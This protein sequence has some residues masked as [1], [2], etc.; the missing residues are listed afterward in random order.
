MAAPAPILHVVYAGRGDAL[1]LE[2]TDNQNVQRFIL[3]D[4]G[5]YNFRAEI[6]APAPYHYY[7]QSAVQTLLPNAEFEGIVLT[8]AD[9]DHFGGLESVG[10]WRW[11]RQEGPNQWHAPLYAPN[12]WLDSIQHI[13]G[14]DHRFADGIAA[15]AQPQALIG[16]LVLLYPDLVNICK[17]TGP[18]LALDQPMRYNPPVALNVNNKNQSSIILATNTQNP[19]F[20]TGDNSAERILHSMDAMWPQA[21]GGPYPQQLVG[22]DRNPVIPRFSVYK[23]QHHGSRL[24]SIL[25]PTGQLLLPRWAEEV[26]IE[27]CV[28]VHLRFALHYRPGLVA[29]G[30][31]DAPIHIAAQRMLV[32]LRNQRG[33]DVATIAQFYDELVARQRIYRAAVVLF[34]AN[35]LVTE[36]PRNAPNLGLIF[37]PQ[38]VMV[39]F[40]RN[41][42]QEL[43]SSAVAGNLFD[44]RQTLVG[45]GQLGTRWD[46]LPKRDGWESFWNDG[47]SWDL[48][49]S[50]NIA[51]C[52]AFF[53]R[54]ESDSYVVSANGSHSHPNVETIIGLSMALK[55]QARAARL[56]VTSAGSIDV[57]LYNHVMEVAFMTQ[58]DVAAMRI[59]IP[60][61][62]ALAQNWV[63]IP[64]NANIID[65]LISTEPPPPP[66]LG[67][68]APGLLV[69]ALDSSEGFN[70]I[71][72]SGRDSQGIFNQAN[73]YDRHTNVNMVFN[74]NLDMAQNVS[75]QHAIQLMHA[76]MEK[77]DLAKAPVTRE[78]VIRPSNLPPL[79]NNDYYLVVNHVDNYL[80]NYQH[81]VVHGNVLQQR[82]D[83]PRVH[84][85][86][87]YMHGTSTYIRIMNDG[88]DWTDLFAKWAP[89][90]GAKDGTDMLW[91][92]TD[93]QNTYFHDN[94]PNAAGQVAFTWGV[95]RENTGTSVTRFKIR[96]ANQFDLLMQ[97]RALLFELARMPTATL[98]LVQYMS[99]LDKQLLT[100]TS[101][102]RAMSTILD[103]IATLVGETSVKEL[104]DTNANTILPR[105][106]KQ[107]VQL[108]GSDVVH[109]F[110]END[111]DDDDLDLS[112]AALAHAVLEKTELKL[113]D[114][115]YA[116]SEVF[117][118][119]TWDTSN[120]L[121]NDNERPKVKLRTTA[122]CV[123]GVEVSIV[124]NVLSTVA[125]S[126]RQK[127]KSL[128]DILG[129]LDA[130][131]GLTLVEVLT[132]VLNDRA[133]ALQ[134]LGKH[135]QRSLL[136]IGFAMIKP[137]FTKS[138]ARTLRTA[139]GVRFIDRATL[140]CPNPLI[141]LPGRSEDPSNG[142]EAIDGAPGK[143]VEI[144]PGLGF[145]FEHV[146]I[147][148]KNVG[149]S[150]MTAA[151]SSSVGLSAHGKS[152]KL[153]MFSEISPTSTQEGGTITDVAESTAAATVEFKLAVPSVDGLK[154]MAL[155]ILGQDRA[156]V[157]LSAPVPVRK[158]GVAPSTKDKP[159]EPKASL[160]YLNDKSVYEVGFTLSQSTPGLSS[161]RLSSI[162]VCTSAFEDWIDYLPV[163]DKFRANL[164]KASVQVSIWNPLGPGS[165][166]PGLQV[167]FQ[168]TVPKA[169]SP[170]P[171][172][173]VEV[174][175]RGSPSVAILFQIMP[176][177][178]AGDYIY[179][180]AV[181]ATDGAHKDFWTEETGVPIADICAAVGMDNVL[182]I[183]TA[184]I[185][186]LDQITKKIQASYLS[187]SIEQRKKDFGLGWAFT[188]W[189]CSLF[190]QEFS[191]I[192]GT[193]DVSNV[194]LSLQRIGDEFRARGEATLVVKATTVTKDEHPLSCIASFALPSHGY[195]GFFRISSPSGISL[196][197]V[198]ALCGNPDLFM[199]VPLLE[200]LAT[201]DITNLELRITSDANSENNKTKIF[202]FL[203]CLRKDAI[204]LG[205][206]KLRPVE[207]FISWSKD[208]QKNTPSITFSATASLECGLRASLEYT[209]SR[210][211]HLISLNLGDGARSA[212]SVKMPELLADL[213]I[214]PVMYEGSALDS[215]VSDLALLEAALVLE[216]DTETHNAEIR[217]AQIGIA[218]GQEKSVPGA[219]STKSV[220][221][222]ELILHYEK[223]V[224]LQGDVALVK[225]EP[226]GASGDWRNDPASP[227]AL[228]KM[229]T[230]FRLEG[231]VRVGKADLKGVL[232]YHS[233]AISATTAATTTATT[234]T[235]PPK[236]TI[237][238]V[239][240]ASEALTLNDVLGAFNLGTL[241]QDLPDGCA[242]FEI[243]LDY[244][245]V[246]L[247][248]NP[249]RAVKPHTQ[250]A[251]PRDKPT[252]SE[253]ARPAPLQLVEA[254]ISV[255]SKSNLNIMTEPYQVTLHSVHLAVSYQHPIPTEQGKTLGKGTLQGVVR[256]TITIDNVSAT[257]EY[258]KDAGGHLYWG[259]IDAKKPQSLQ[260]AQK[261]VSAEGVLSTVLPQTDYSLEGLPS[262]IPLWR[263]DFG[264]RPKR[265]FF[266][267]AMGRAGSDTEA[268]TV[269]VAN[270]TL[271]LRE[272]GLRIRVTKK[273]ESEKT[274][275]EDISEQPAL[276]NLAQKKLLTE[277]SRETSQSP[278]SKSS[279]QQS[280][281]NTKV[282]SWEKSVFL[283]GTLEIP[284]IA[285]S[286]T[287]YLRIQP[288][289]K[290][291][292]LAQATISDLKTLSIAVADNSESV[293]ALVGPDAAGLDAVS[294][295]SATVAVNMGDKSLLVSGQVNDLGAALFYVKKAPS[296]APADS[297]NRTVDTRADKNTEPSSGKPAPGHEYVFLL[298]AT[299]LEQ[300]WS[301]GD[302]KDE[303]VSAFHID[304]VLA[305]VVSG[306]S[307]V[308]SL[309]VELAEHQE[310][311]RES[312]DCFAELE[313][314]LGDAH[315]MLED[316]GP[317]TKRGAQAEGSITPTSKNQGVGLPNG[318]TTSLDAL[319]IPITEDIP[320]DRSAWFFAEI[321]ISH[322]NASPDM[323]QSL[324]FSTDT[325]PLPSNTKIVLF[326]SMTP[327]SSGKSSLY[328]ISVV[329]LPLLYG[330]VVVDRAMGSYA[331]GKVD[332]NPPVARCLRL[333]ADLTI[334]GGRVPFHVSTEMILQPNLVQ[335]NAALDAS[336]KP[337]GS[338]LVANP[339]D[340]MFNITL[341]QL[342]VSGTI[343]RNNRDKSK[344][345]FMARIAAKVRF[346]NSAAASPKVSGEIIIIN[347]KPTAFL[348]TYKANEEASDIFERIITPRPKNDNKHVGGKKAITWPG[349]DM[350]ARIQ[351]EN[352]FAYY[353]T[354]AV[355]F[356]DITNPKKQRTFL[357]PGFGMGADID[358]FGKKLHVQG[359]ISREGFEVTGTY[360]E[361]VALPFGRIKGIVMN[362][363]T[364]ER[365]SGPSLKLS[366]LQTK[367]E[368]SIS[369]G[370]SLFELDVGDIKL[371]YRPREK[372]IHADITL[373]VDMFP[374]KGSSISFSYRDKRLHFEKWGLVN[375][376]PFDLEDAM[377]LKSLT[378]TDSCGIIVKNV[379]NKAVQ[380]RAVFSLNTTNMTYE[381]AAQKLY[382]SVKWGCKI[383]MGSIEIL[384]FPIGELPFELSEPAKHE[385]LLKA[386]TRSALDSSVAI[387]TRIL[388]DGEMLGK[389][390]TYV[391]VKHLL[392]QAIATLMCKG[393][394]AIKWIRDVASQ[395]GQWFK[396][397]FTK[398]PLALPVIGSFL[399]AVKG[400]AVGAFTIAISADLLLGVVLVVGAIMLV[401]KVTEIIRS[402]KGKSEEQRK[403]D[404][405]LIKQLEEDKKEIERQHADAMKRWTEATDK[406][407]ASIQLKGLPVARYRTPESSM[408]DI[409]WA[410]CVPDTLLEPPKATDEIR[411]HWEVDISTT[412]DFSDAKPTKVTIDIPNDSDVL[413]TAQL[414]KSIPTETKAF[415]RVRAVFTHTGKPPEGGEP[416]S[417]AS[418]PSE[419]VEVTKSDG[420][421][422]RPLGLTATADYPNSRRCL[423][424]VPLLD[425][426]HYELQ[427]VTIEDTTSMLQL[428]STSFSHTKGVSFEKALT[429]NTKASLP[430]GIIKV[431]VQM[432]MISA[433]PEHAIGPP[434][435]T[436]TLKISDWDREVGIASATL[437]AREYVWDV[438]LAYS[439]PTRMLELTWKSPLEVNDHQKAYEV[440]LMNL[441]KKRPIHKTWKRFNM[442]PIEGGKYKTVTETDNL[443]EQLD[444]GDEMGVTVVPMTVVLTAP[445]GNEMA[446]G[447]Q[448]IISTR[449]APKVT[450]SSDSVHWDLVD[451]VLNFTIHYDGG[452]DMDKDLLMAQVI[453]TS[454]SN[455]FVLDT[456]PGSD[457]RVSLHQ[458]KKH[459]HISI[460]TPEQSKMTALRQM[461]MG[462]GAR[463]N[464]KPDGPLAII[465]GARATFDTELMPTIPVMADTKVVINYFRPKAGKST[466]GVTEFEFQWALPTE[467]LFPVLKATIIDETSQENM[468]SKDIDTSKTD[469]AGAGEWTVKLPRNIRALKLV[470]RPMWRG[471]FVGQE[472]FMTWNTQPPWADFGDVISVDCQVGQHSGLVVLSRQ[473]PSANV[474]MV[475]LFWMDDKGTMTSRVFPDNL[476]SSYTPLMVALKE[477]SNANGYA[478]ACISTSGSKE[479]A[480]WINFN[481]EVKIADNRDGHWAT[482]F[483]TLNSTIVN[484]A[485]IAHGGSIA[486]AAEGDQSHVWWIAADKS[487]THRTGRPI[488][489]VIPQA[490]DSRVT[491]S[492]PSQFEAYAGPDA[493]S[494]IAGV[495]CEK[496]TAV[497]FINRDLNLVSVTT[498]PK[499]VSGAT[500][501][502]GIIDWVDYSTVDADQELVQEANP[503]AD[504]TV[505]PEPDTK[506]LFRVF[507]IAKDYSVMTALETVNSSFGQGRLRKS[508]DVSY[509]SSTG[510]AGPRS[511][512]AA[513][514]VTNAL[515]VFWFNTAGSILCTV[516]PGFSH[517]VTREWEQD[518][519]V[520]SDARPRKEGRQILR[521]TMWDGAALR[522]WWLDED[523]SL[524]CAESKWTTMEWDIVGE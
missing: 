183:A 110:H 306:R 312:H 504:L 86:E 250:D 21:G 101:V 272:F 404:E 242:P 126:P 37:D 9:D 249:V 264:F 332:A 426:G 11:N 455:Q 33:A 388:E 42:T 67:G 259:F 270:T 283:S 268:W 324:A 85:T 145:T 299:R 58:N 12:Y 340:G 174:T 94:L 323:S 491:T 8:H 5:P 353:N 409:R 369:F 373:N 123:D 47:W 220:V 317:E 446:I 515:F 435:N 260:P 286:A 271:R 224:D 184:N 439:W 428:V 351:L 285:T 222:K 488:Q 195:D 371:A 520:V 75:Q 339:F 366:A 128:V 61:A 360:A 217:R 417:I 507:W 296:K 363:T 131:R 127:T 72:L 190:V 474:R 393:A 445:V 396:S 201:I 292:L 311:V 335:F 334:S 99:H 59:N 116:I 169:L 90:S 367:R 133:L 193:L 510:S 171:P 419:T 408:A 20:L 192:P 471:I 153:S 508:E 56:Y 304:R 143:V 1:I 173:S 52:R 361:E 105:L 523:G 326:A 451:Q 64:N 98:D 51:K 344:R 359:S 114:N 364:N 19:I 421:L 124:K 365:D 287:A 437:S 253:N 161:T 137:D 502:N 112:S 280:T 152:I 231:L 251:A 303:V 84:V 139:T 336:S 69:T 357:Y 466:P 77:S 325:A 275:A 278:P 279:P 430:S 83:S 281:T 383:M 434:E 140:V 136:D 448:M 454:D 261:D 236:K 125:P 17:Y 45:A 413:G 89:L 385:S 293:G 382:L 492:L 420:Y 427:L 48:H 499:S 394:R 81:E 321:R 134:I 290:S 493:V 227:E 438:A 440:S 196:A 80:V 26:Q 484:A 475:K 459:A 512:I 163:P 74:V 102:P 156:N 315:E 479:Q 500:E 464:G 50:L 462:V 167:R 63:G 443:L 262:K 223:E 158:G 162:Y 476:A 88:G 79:V 307:S 43:C 346:G 282:E 30:T 277:K 135:L 294:L 130:T 267:R 401:A 273:L 23:I 115:M 256:G 228:S 141:S 276:Q 178:A 207:F 229:T 254:S 458:G 246:K 483:P 442:K 7:L 478:I 314:K 503:C 467:A 291:I 257:L 327:K 348:M 15:P 248:T 103:V 225:A 157:V 13:L 338:E 495:V 107:P 460:P 447:R 453:G 514:E 415:V 423:V 356:V 319:S 93:G 377:H 149:R 82:G 298:A 410:H 95:F 87:R 487:D 482:E 263:V 368:F 450:I 154:D 381:K 406:F 202:G 73:D 496:A 240:T 28:F 244:I 165:P 509:C 375:P 374:F 501:R 187:L 150:N 60:G 265:S 350:P 144:L 175:E 309:A 295:G 322:D 480:Y 36:I 370:L 310:L 121:S 6:H 46:R 473:P 146:I 218:R 333:K 517:G 57:P 198:A 239:L 477:G 247:E 308:A 432:R 38:D 518:C 177:V 342:S 384:E 390:M 506:D 463:T 235:S 234:P 255:K 243:G 170:N 210:S 345:L 160:D 96:G 355:G 376:L 301:R 39:D 300:I 34:F 302:T 109:F 402:A 258:R 316:A 379:F 53:N 213:G 519:V 341:E 142:D 66:L 176:L 216:Y 129:H 151:L 329:N 200:E 416:L 92:L 159:D 358:I 425:V 14:K 288:G 212:K 405:A 498:K 274:L 172:S 497:W 330:C 269:D 347:G 68:L 414:E 436:G 147:E 32:S 411:L 472:T 352:A 389:I 252:S 76:V 397:I 431:Q 205:G 148:L 65:S 191:I 62:Q 513:I 25:F 186:I 164:E 429:Y 70:F 221:L 180:L 49:H 522:L 516:S 113:D 22:V 204:T 117:T 481:G 386:L 349:E 155:A 297:S 2:H 449:W 78:M 106:L 91:T 511:G 209:H 337:T 118:T 215:V 392:P 211:H 284:G 505:I 100:R 138:T 119:L 468:W 391:G 181:D 104:L 3:I 521:V 188:D 485:E 372:D 55:D 433:S 203:V 168:L 469:T 122:H 179:N 29:H 343:T 206:L 226:A 378:A 452:P 494:P 18:H 380:T 318:S 27:C 31:K 41:M 422:P 111:F 354:G 71:S 456:Q 185:P 245:K 289:K 219:D 97:K 387:V 465:W 412:R 208:L 120:P 24:D 189:A 232:L 424:R 441:T 108:V 305:C 241:Q 54:F 331:P 486:V 328:Q 166:R 230:V 470:L 395:I 214:L 320:L 400:S 237:N 490:D 132:L 199:G 16:N 407:K 418:L 457:N 489:H 524:R 362:E 44:I 313:T 197:R 40:H 233:H 461:S 182:S 10:P 399:L 4:A 266:I 238:F 444:V 403:E 194:R 35:G 398:L